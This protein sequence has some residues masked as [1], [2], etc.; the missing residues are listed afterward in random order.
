[1]VVHYCK[2]VNFAVDISQDYIFETLG[3]PDRSMVVRNVHKYL[4]TYGTRLNR[5]R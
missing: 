2:S 3:A 1:M 4:M 5:N